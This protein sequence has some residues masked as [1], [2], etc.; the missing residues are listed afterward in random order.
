MNARTH[1]QRGRTRCINADAGQK[2]ARGSEEFL[3]RTRHEFGTRRMELYVT[4]MTTSN[5]CPMCETVFFFESCNG[6]SS[7]GA[8]F[9]NGKVFCESIC[10]CP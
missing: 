9:L 7:R 8:R 2:R 10:A 3:K 5:V 4:T 1:S 6:E